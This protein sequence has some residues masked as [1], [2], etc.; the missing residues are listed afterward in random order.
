MAGLDRARSLPV[1]RGYLEVSGGYSPLA[2]P[3]ARLELGAR[4]LDP[5]S[6]F[7]A[8]QWTPRES[9]V[10]GGVRVTW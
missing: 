1:G 4:P 6:L 7:A 8:G 2:G 9:M 5:L 10:V 3:F